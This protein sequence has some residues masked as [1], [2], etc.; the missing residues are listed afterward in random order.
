MQDLIAE[1]RVDCLLNGLS[2][3]TIK[4]YAALIERFC[5]DH[6]DRPPGSFAHADV[7]RYLHGLMS[8]KAL[9]K[10]SLRSAAT[11]EQYRKALKC[12]FAWLEAREHI[13]ASP[14]AHIRF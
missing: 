1:F 12:W 13:T 10:D 6:P 8:S 2:D 11:A 4:V 7:A 9:R 14:M 3:S 5:A